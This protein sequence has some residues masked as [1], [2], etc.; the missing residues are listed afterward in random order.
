M[1]KNRNEE[2]LQYLNLINEIIEKNN[3]EIETEIQVQNS[4]I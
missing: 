2:E 4:G 3:C 1:E